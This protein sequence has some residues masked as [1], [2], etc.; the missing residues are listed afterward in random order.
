MESQL[1][2]SKRLLTTFDASRRKKA[3]KKRGTGDDV[4][5]PA[6]DD[7]IGVS[8]SQELP[9]VYNIIVINNSYTFF[10]LEEKY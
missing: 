5:T 3:K 4:I 7:S 10:L 2:E 1:D 8:N 6:T 9:T